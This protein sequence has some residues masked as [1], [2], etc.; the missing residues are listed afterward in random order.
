MK[1]CLLGHSALIETNPL[2]FTEV[3]RQEPAAGQVV[4]S[5]SCCGVCRTDLHGVEGTLTL[6]KFPVIPR[7]SSRGRRRK[8]W[9]KP[10]EI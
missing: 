8:D 4:L 9:R 10:T 1:A 7:T 6:R 2:K 3:Q 5:V